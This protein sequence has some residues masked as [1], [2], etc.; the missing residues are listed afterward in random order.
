MVTESYAILYFYHL[1]LLWFIFGVSLAAHLNSS[2]NLA[3][4][5]SRTGSMLCF[6]I[7]LRIFLA[8]DSKFDGVSHGLILHQVTQG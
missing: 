1:V 8:S 6:C 7:F 2:Y 3:R 4:T 5:V